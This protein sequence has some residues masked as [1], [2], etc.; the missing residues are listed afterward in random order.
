MG[1][2]FTDTEGK[3]KKGANQYQYK[4]G[5]NI[6]RF[7]GDVMPRYVYWLKSK[8]GK[9][10]PV[11]CLSFDRA[12]EKFTNVEKDWVRHFFPELKCS[13]SYSIQAFDESDGKVYLVNLKKKLF[14]AIKVTAED[15]GDPTD[16]EAGWSVCFKKVKTGALAYNVEYQLQPLRCKPR[17]LTDEE[18]E[19]VAKLKPIDELIPRLTSA[20]QKEF[21]EKT[22]LGKTD[23]EADVPAEFNN[24][25]EGADDLP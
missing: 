7:V 25:D 3:A 24:K 21:I 2:K 6:L 12:Q 16:P 15:L 13:W 23:D 17:P 8:E 22:I 5:D 11:E 19:I 18:K 1:I 10:I 14:E 20:E 4:D 9:D